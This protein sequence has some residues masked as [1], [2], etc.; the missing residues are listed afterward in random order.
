MDGVAKIGTGWRGGEVSAMSSKIGTNAREDDILAQRPSPA[1]AREAVNHRRRRDLICFG[2][3]VAC[4]QFNLP[5]PGLDMHD[6]LEDD[7]LRASVECTSTPARLF[8][9]ARVSCL[10]ISREPIVN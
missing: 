9:Q 5:R 10:T 4:G 2:R 1:V 3:D 8:M 6:L 7:S